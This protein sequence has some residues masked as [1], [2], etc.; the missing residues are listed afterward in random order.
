MDEG[1]DQRTE[2]AADGEKVIGN[3][4]YDSLMSKKASIVRSHTKH[5]SEPYH[6]KSLRDE[7]TNIN[8]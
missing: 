2:E 6:Q 1:G 3:S 4:Q 7:S 8:M 5:N